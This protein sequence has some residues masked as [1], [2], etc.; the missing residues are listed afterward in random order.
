MKKSQE[1]MK[2]SNT[3]KKDMDP[4]YIKIV[5]DPKKVQGFESLTHW[6]RIPLGETFKYS[7]GFE[8][9]SHKFESLNLQM[10]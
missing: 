10:Q 7:L 5:F 4:F 8:S 1:H 6:I 9:S 2:D 3:Q